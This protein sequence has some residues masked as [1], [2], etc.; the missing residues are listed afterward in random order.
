MSRKRNRR[1]SDTP[2]LARWLG[3]GLGTGNLD[4]WGDVNLSFAAHVDK[5]CP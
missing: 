4:T 3:T 1:I 2:T 5:N